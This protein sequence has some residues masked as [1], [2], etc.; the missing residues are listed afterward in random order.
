MRYV[1]YI[2]WFFW[3][4]LLG[5]YLENQWWQKEAVKAGHAKIYTDQEGDRR[6]AWEDN[7]Q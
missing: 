7:C 3:G 5:G 6:F 2:F 4:L 1:A